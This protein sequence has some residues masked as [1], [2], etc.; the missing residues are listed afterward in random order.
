MKKIVMV[1][2]LFVS[3]EF[4]LA[5]ECPQIAD[6]DIYNINSILFSIGTDMNISS[7]NEKIGKIEQRIFNWGRTFELMDPQGKLVA[8]ASQRAFS[9]GVEINVVDCQNR[10]IGS[11]KENIL[12]SLF[13]VHT[14]YSISGVDGA[15]IGQSTKIELLSTTVRFF[16][17]QNHELAK[18]HRPF[19]SWPTEKWQLNKDH[20]TEKMDDRLLV[21]V[22]AYKTAA[23]KARRAESDSKA[24]S[25]ARSGSR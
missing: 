13:K 9:W 17:R 7:G 24:R 22:A 5:T 18:L 25:S 16:N 1:L 2:L 10:F 19:A 3:F 8:T 23:D 21:F 15:L 20:L 14:I 4:S 11:I 6:R 12:D